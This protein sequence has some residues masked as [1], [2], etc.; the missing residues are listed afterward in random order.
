MEP[1]DGFTRRKLVHRGAVGLGG[2]AGLSLLGGDVA[3]AKKKLPAMPRPIPGGFDANFNIV[4]DNAAFHVLPPG[5]GFEMSTIT[6]FNGV[7]AGSEIRGTAH[8]SDGSVWDFDTDMRFMRGD[9][10]GV[11]GRVHHG[12]FG[13][14]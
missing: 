4:P 10:V 11:D 7:V 3:I 14:I 1:Q 8:G 13:F 5:V 6:D 2:L 9:F 12:T